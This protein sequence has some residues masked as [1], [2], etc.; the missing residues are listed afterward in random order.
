MKVINAPQRSLDWHRARLGVIT[1]SEV[2]KLIGSGRGKDKEF[3]DTGLSYIN[4]LIFQ[5]DMNPAIITDDELFQKYLDMNSTT[6][7][8][9]KWGIEYEEEARS[10]YAELNNVHVVETSL[11]LHPIIEGF[12]SS[13]DG[14]CDYDD[15]NRV[16]LEI[17]CPQGGEYIRYSR[18]RT[19]E[20]L[21]H[22]KPE[23]YW[24]CLAHMSVTGA[25]RTD[26]IA[27]NPMVLHPYH[28]LPVPRELVEADIDLLISRVQQ[29]INLIKP[30]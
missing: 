29:A 26:F 8:A 30:I 2:H 15:G 19:P 5:S 4:N 23:Y 22:G 14:Y 6:S 10:I 28:C 25:N 9:M 21:K 18:F 16:C 11:V 20:D 27:Y 13:P 1:G 17:K 7:K 3:T 12:G 24:Q